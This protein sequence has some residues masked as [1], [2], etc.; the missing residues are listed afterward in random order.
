MSARIGVGCLTYNRPEHYELWCKQ[1]EKFGGD[2]YLVVGVG[3][4]HDGERKG[5]AYRSNELLRHLKDCDYVFLFNDDCFPIAPGWAEWFIEAYKTCSQHHFL[6]LKETPTIKKTDSKRV[7]HSVYGFGYEGIEINS[8]NNC[9]GCFM[10]LTKKVIEKVGAFNEEFGLYSFEHAE[11]SKRIHLA[12]LTPM[13]EYLCPAGADKYIYSMDLQNNLPFNKAV[14]HR[15][16]MKATEA[17]EH[18]KK[19]QPIFEKP[20]LQIHRPL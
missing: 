18:I 3:D 20:I 2:D 12:G 15:P 6:F 8:F 16:S 13:G 17:I 4:G 19:A 10:F 5:V 1:I 7:Q 14:K 9:S 11:Y